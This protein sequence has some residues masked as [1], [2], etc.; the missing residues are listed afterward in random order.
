MTATRQ[1]V[2]QRNGWSLE[3]LEIKVERYNGQ[4]LNQETLLVT[5]LRIEGGNWDKNN[6]IVPI[7]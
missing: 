1:F 6:L 4:A 3:E 7:Q 5:G 2:A